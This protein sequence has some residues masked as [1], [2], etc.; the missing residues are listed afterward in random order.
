MTLHPCLCHYGASCDEHGMTFIQDSGFV[1]W[2]EGGTPPAQ[3]GDAS[4]G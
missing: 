4:D 3:K 2:Y 1:S